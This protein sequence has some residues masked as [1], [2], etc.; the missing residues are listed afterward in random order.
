[1]RHEIL[2]NDGWRFHRGD[3]TVDTPAYKGPVYSQSK[4]ERKKSGPAAYAYSDAPDQF[5]SNS[6]ILNH[7]KWENVNLPHDYVVD[8]DMDENE[9]NA[10]GYLHYDNA[11][12]RKHFSLSEEYRNKRVVLRFDGIA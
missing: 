10:L 2:L 7:E 9:N 12:Y 6:G 3:I 1:M 5:V 8:Q 4:T 11:W